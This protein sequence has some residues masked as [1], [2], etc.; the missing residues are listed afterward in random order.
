MHQEYLNKNNNDN[1]VFESELCGYY[2]VGAS[3]ILF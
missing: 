1:S 3:Y 2:V